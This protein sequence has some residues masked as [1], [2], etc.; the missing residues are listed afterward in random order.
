RRADRPRLQLQRAVPQPLPRHPPPRS[1]HP[2]RSLHPHR[3]PPHPPR[4]GSVRGGCLGA[5]FATDEHGWTRIGQKRSGPKRARFTHNALLSCICVHPCSSVAE[6]LFF[7]TEKG[8]KYLALGDSYTIGEGVPEAGR[9]PVV[10]A[11]ALRAE[12]VAL[13]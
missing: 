13:G 2:P 3:P 11:R 1:R 7:S 9:W 12:G 6:K 10:L 5:F 8:M 4:C